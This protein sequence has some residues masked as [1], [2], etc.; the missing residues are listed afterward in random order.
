MSDI[1]MLLAGKKHRFADRRQ[2]GKA[3]FKNGNLIYKGVKYCVESGYAYFDIDTLD[4]G[5]IQK[6][7]EFLHIGISSDEFRH[8]VMDN[9]D[10]QPHLDLYISKQDFLKI[11]QKVLKTEGKLV[12]SGDTE[13]ELVSDHFL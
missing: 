6:G 11:A 1:D 13:Q 7:G 10:V 3:V 12:V 8:E 9:P 2:I 4:D 5:K